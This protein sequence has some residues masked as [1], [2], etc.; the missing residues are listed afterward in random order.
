MSH[1]IWMS[2]NEKLISVLFFTI[3]LMLEWFFV[4]KLKGSPAHDDMYTQVEQTIL[5]YT[6]RY[7]DLVDDEDGGIRPFFDTKRD[8]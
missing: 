2:S 1:G 8:S 3:R 6:E 4:K 5:F 7:I